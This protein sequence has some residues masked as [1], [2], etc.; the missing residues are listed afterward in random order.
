MVTKAGPYIE[1][2]IWMLFF[3]IIAA[4]HFENWGW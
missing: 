1:A 3:A 2:A 4:N